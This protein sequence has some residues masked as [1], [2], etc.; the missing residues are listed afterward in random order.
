MAS[1]TP[2]ASGLWSDSRRMSYFSHGDGDEDLEALVAEA[3]VYDGRSP[4]DRTIDR[5]GMG[6]SSSSRASLAC[7]THS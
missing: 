5:I 6:A 1:L 7:L 2:R 4:L 3:E